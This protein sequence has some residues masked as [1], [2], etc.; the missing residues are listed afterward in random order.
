MYCRKPAAG[1]KNIADSH[2]PL[3]AREAK[4]VRDEVLAFLAA[5]G[6]LEDSKLYLYDRRDQNGDT[7]ARWY[8]EEFDLGEP[9]A[10]LALG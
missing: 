10:R 8:Y 5:G 9:P 3:Y 4:L 2:V 7:T 1:D 6:S